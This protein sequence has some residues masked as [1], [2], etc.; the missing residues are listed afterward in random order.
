MTALSGGYVTPG[1]FADPAY[2]DSIPTGHMGR[3][4]D[5]TKMPTKAAYESAVKVVDLLLVN[6]YENMAR[7]QVTAL[8][9]GELK[10]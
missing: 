7:W 3:T 1:L 9:Y 4:S 8:I 6:Y 5:T 2:A 10:Y